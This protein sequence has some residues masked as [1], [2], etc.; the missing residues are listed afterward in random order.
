MEAPS[1]GVRPRIERAH[2]LAAA[3][4]VRA[5]LLARAAVADVRLGPVADEA[6][7]VVELVR[8]QV[9][10]LGALPV[11]VLRVVVEAAVR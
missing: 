4:G 1:L 11:V 9:L 3:V 6:P 2:D 7:L 8:P 5:G 10:A